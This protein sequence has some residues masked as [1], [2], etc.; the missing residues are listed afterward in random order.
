L[1]ALGDPGGE[2]NL[3]HGNIMLVP[4]SGYGYYLPGLDWLPGHQ[5]GNPTLTKGM[6]LLAQVWHNAHQT[7]TF[8]CTGVLPYRPHFALMTF[9]DRAW[10][11]P[12]SDWPLYT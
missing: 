12:W 7:L 2:H 4:N 3:E 9:A 5:S 1:F 10:G 6:R 8:D 11:P